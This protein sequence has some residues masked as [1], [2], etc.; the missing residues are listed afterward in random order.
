MSKFEATQLDLRQSAHTQDLAPA[1][2]FSSPAYARAMTA[3]GYTPLSI[4]GEDVTGE[5]RATIGFLKGGRLNKTLLCPTLPRLAS[6]APFWHSLIGFCR[7]RGVTELSLSSAASEGVFIPPITGEFERIPRTEF[8]LD[9][10]REDL[11]AGVGRSHRDRIKKARKLGVSIAVSTTEDALRSHVELHSN[12][13]HRRS[14]RGETV[15]LDE[16]DVFMRHLLSSGAG[17]LYQAVLDG[18][19]LSSLLMVRSAKGAYSQSSGNSAEGMSIGA[20]HFLRYETACAMKLLGIEAFF[21]GGCRPH[22]SGLRMY[23][24]GFGA[25]AI[26]MESVEAYLGSRIRRRLSTAA[27]L[28]RSDPKAVPRILAGSTERFVVFSAVPRTVDPPE[29]VAGWEI[30]KLS[31]EELRELSGDAPEIHAQRERLEAGRVNDA[32][33]LR[34]DGTLA[35]ICWMIPEV[36]DRRYPVRNVKLRPGEVEITHCVTLPS[37][38]GRGV[39]PFMIRWLCRRAA[40]DGVKRIFMIT[41]ETNV[42][43]QRGIEKAGLR[44]DGRIWRH[45]FEVFPG[46]PAITWRVLSRNRA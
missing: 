43:S 22:E 16:D 3:V 19:V 1:N 20:S 46:S 38:R 26:P 12:S 36:N 24:E 44:R 34:I 5:V 2:P 39:Y 15:P 31:D 42:A 14:A 6:T 40:E 25:R 35:G 17:H 33:G 21:L 23:K 37:F 18:R 10:T 27:R 32:W 11:W 13:M 28:L 8:L 9:L 41:S 29:A 45:V 7:T 30:A 4:V